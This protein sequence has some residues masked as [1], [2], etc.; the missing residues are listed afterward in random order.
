[1]SRILEEDIELWT[2][3]YSF[4]V[5]DKQHTLVKQKA[6]RL[7]IKTRSEIY[8]LMVVSF[9]NLPEN[10]N[11]VE[12]EEE[13]KEPIYPY[14]I[15]GPTL[16]AVVKFH[17]D[18]PQRFKEACL[19]YDYDNESFYKR[20]LQFITDRRVDIGD[21]EK[22]YSVGRARGVKA[23]AQR[24]NKLF[25]SKITLPKGIPDKKRKRP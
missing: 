6:R 13:S 16:E 4:K 23:Y 2:T 18:H 5:L 1:M 12:Q 9:M 7:G 22:L 3:R 8:N 17:D 21:E 15:W 20:S 14:S 19:Q 25:D 10:E 11:T 24:I